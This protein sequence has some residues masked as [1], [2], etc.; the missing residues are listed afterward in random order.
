MLIFVARLCSQVVE[1]I[2]HGIAEGWL[3]ATTLTPTPKGR[4]I[5]AFSRD[6]SRAVD[7]SPAEA[8]EAAQ[9]LSTVEAEQVVD[10]IN[11]LCG[12]ELVS[13]L[14]LQRAARSP[15]VLRGPVIML[16]IYGGIFHPEEAAAA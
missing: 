16:E 8:M 14:R 3:D 9:W 7:A 4:S 1:D 2:R 15:A 12:R 11:Q 10:M 13:T 5:V 6:A